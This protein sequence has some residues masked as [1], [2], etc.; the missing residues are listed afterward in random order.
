LGENKEKD[1]ESC[2]EMRKTRY[3]QLTKLMNLNEGEP[4]FYLRAQ[5]RLSVETLMEYSRLLERES[6]KAR[7]EGNEVLARSLSDQSTEV[8]IYA[9]K[10]LDWQQ[11]HP[12]KVKLPD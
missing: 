2:V 6:W 8:A 9:H 3:E 4:W 12:D 5:D 11:E 1:E 10:F 7:G